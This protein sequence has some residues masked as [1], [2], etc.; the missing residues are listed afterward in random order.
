M[1]FSSSSGVV[2]GVLAELSASSQLSTVFSALAG[3]G[4]TGDSEELEELAPPSSGLADLAG[5][6][7]EL[8]AGASEPE[9]KF[10]FSIEEKIVK[11][12]FLVIFQ[13]HD[14]IEGKIR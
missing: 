2:A 4:A 14:F 11:K 13:C 10:K 1:E 9:I 5:E 3:A 7:L 6:P 12:I 8:L